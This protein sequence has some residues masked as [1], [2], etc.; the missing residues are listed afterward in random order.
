MSDSIEDIMGPGGMLSDAHGNYEH[1]PQQ[2]AMAEAVDDALTRRRPLIVEA[3]TGT[4]KTLAYLIP[5]LLSKRRVVVSTGTKALQGQLFE[6][7]LPFLQ[8]HWPSPFQ[9][10]Q[11][12]GRRNYLCKLRFEE[13]RGQ[14]RFR[15]RED[16]RMWPD[17]IRWAAKTETG[18]RAEIPGL[19]DDYA[20]WS[21]LSVGSEGCLGKK[22]QFY[23]DC[24]VFEARRRAQ[25]ADIIVVNHH[26]F[27][28]DLALRDQGITELLPEYDAVIF[29]EAHHI[30]GVAT[31]Y[32]GLQVSNWRFKELV[33]DIR[34][35]MDVEEVEDDDVDDALD[36][37]S[38]TSADFFNLLTFGLNNGRYA[39]EEVL[40]S[41]QSEK[42]READQ[43]LRDALTQL[44]RAVARLASLGDVG[45][46]LAE[47]CTEVKLDLA[48]IINRHHS[49]Y[50]YL[51]EQRDKGVFLQAMPIDVAGLVRA[52]L[53]DT[54]DTLV[55]TSATL[56][57]AG[58]FEYFKQRLGMVPEGDDD[59]A[60]GDFDV[61]ELL[62]EPVFDYDDQCVLYVPRKLPAPND[63]E[64]VDNVAL[65]VEYLLGV[66]DGRAFVLFTSYANMNAVYDIVASELDYTVLKQGERPKSEIL[67]IFREDSHS[68]LFATGSFWE[69]VDVEGDAL[70][71][72]I[73]DKLP[74]ANPSDPLT[75]A[76]LD[77]IDAV[78]GNSFRD[79]SMPSAALSLK[80]GFGRLIRSRTDTGIV[81]ILD[82][83]IATRRY[84][85][86]F[87][88]SL[89]PAPLAW[90]A[91]QVKH[92][93]KK[94]HP[95][96]A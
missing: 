92:W 13:M 46:R 79:Y 75:R 17:I 51:L 52:K 76:R 31:S 3:A 61:D 65:I 47:R 43:E 24:F 39:L 54:H 84:G 72:V 53:L 78:G 18:D 74:F 48:T 29:D 1:R 40:D 63:P 2:I 59:D 6:K 91:P 69:G 55:F 88:D 56:A 36:D 45:E 70:S 90:T 83:R 80:Q 73:I 95:E 58:D 44:N 81:A 21:D 25:D 8:E 41:S 9:T 93:W 23:D 28:A 57:T 19:P 37:L 87:L 49:E 16:A 22:C 67:E 66:T 86:Y 82:S 7:D 94:K 89:P 4:G 42:I 64:F 5:A 77:H 27:F 12:K 33:G 11:L 68:V 14:P 32:F 71:M 26:L 96:D 62:L 60:R 10:V 50:A 38:N 30:E 35:E 15:K 20:A 85:S 34:R